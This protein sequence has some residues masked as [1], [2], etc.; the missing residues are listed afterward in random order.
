MY[1]ELCVEGVSF[2][3]VVE[4]PAEYEVFDFSK[5]YDS[6][7]TLKYPYGIGKYNEHRPTMYVGEQFLEEQRTV[8]MGIDIAAPVGTAIN[9]F[10]DGFIF[11]L[12]NNDLPW[13]YGPTIITEHHWLGQ[14]IFALHGHLSERSLK[15]WSIGDSISKGAVVGRIGAKTEN[16][17]RSPLADEHRR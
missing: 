16:G 14:R 6:E 12:G 15:L 11:A 7:R 13:D 10:Y 8:H 3:T 9:A 2:G 1:P 5:G 4:L 17:G